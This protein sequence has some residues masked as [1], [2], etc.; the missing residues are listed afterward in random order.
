M[1]RLIGEDCGG[2]LI[3]EASQP[4]AIGLRRNAGL[5]AARQHGD[6]QPVGIVAL[7][8]DHG[9]GVWQALDN[10]RR[11]FNIAMLRRLRG[12]R[13]LAFVRQQD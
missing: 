9:F 11:V 5:D 12:N 1:L 7:S 13:P 6:A 4:C 3:V 10:E 8:A 2:G